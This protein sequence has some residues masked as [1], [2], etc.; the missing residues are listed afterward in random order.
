L[1]WWGVGGGLAGVLVTAEGFVGNFIGNCLRRVE[2][3]S[4][5][6]LHGPVPVGTV[7]PLTDL[8]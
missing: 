2:T 4:G 5:D 6:T 3:K 8:L 7:C 1:D